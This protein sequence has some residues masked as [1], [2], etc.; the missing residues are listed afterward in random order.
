M[1]I[2][3]KEHSTRLLPHSPQS[4]AMASQSQQP[5]SPPPPPEPTSI[6][7]LTDDLLREIFLRLPDLPTLVRAAITCRPF[8]CLVRSSP[9]FRRRFRELHAPPIL[10]LFLTPYMRAVIPSAS[11]SPDPDTT[12]AFADLLGDDDATEWGT[13][14]Q[15][16]YSDGYVAFVNRSTDQTASYSPLNIGAPA[17]AQ[18]LD[19]YPKPPREGVD[20]W[21]EFYTLPPDQ[22]GQRPSRVVCV[23]HDSSW[24]CARVAV[25]SSHAMKCQIFPESRGLLLERDRCTIRKLVH[26]FVCWLQSEN[27]IL[28]LNTV[29]FQFS[30]MY[31]PPPLRGPYTYLS[32][33][34][35]QTK[36]GKLCI[37]HLQEF[38]LSVWLWTPDDDGVER[39][40]LH[41]MFQLHTIVKEITKRSVLDNVDAGEHMNVTDGFVYLSVVHGRGMQSSQWFL[42]FCLETAEVKL[43]FEK[44]C[45]IRCLVDPYIMAWPPSLMHDKGDSETEVAGDTVGDDGPVGTEEVSPVLFTA[46]QSFK[47]ALIDDDNAKLVE[48]DAF[49]VDDEISSLLNKI[50]TLEAGLAAGRDCVLRRA[51]SNIYVEGVERRSWWEMCKGMLGRVSSHFFAN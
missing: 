40:M 20:A 32:F 41:K 33:E 39:F 3:E 42:S 43:L 30:R 27:C 4:T 9:A 7:S 50:S 11:G 45:R 1:P 47:E 16:P 12:A 24:A 29:T 35:G 2:Q 51:H 6:S 13:D 23:R 38:T 10:A 36:D 5:P 28:A 25:F 22:E 26:G 31:L 14:S 19:I 15:I 18:A 21:L 17:Q 49:L 48:M 34:L 37:V 46:L 8:L 44:T